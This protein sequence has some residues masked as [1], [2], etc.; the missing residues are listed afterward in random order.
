MAVGSPCLMLL[1]SLGLVTALRNRAFT[2]RVVMQ[3]IQQDRD[4]CSPERN[5]SSDNPKLDEPIHGERPP[6]GLRTFCTSSRNSAAQVIS[7][8]AGFNFAEGRSVPR[9]PASIPRVLQLSVQKKQR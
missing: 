7:Q 2:F 3:S 9:A 4:H 6:C 8:F 1:C 5:Q